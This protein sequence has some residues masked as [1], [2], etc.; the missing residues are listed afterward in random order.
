MHPVST[1]R[2]TLLFG[3]NKVPPQKKKTFTPGGMAGCLASWYFSTNLKNISQNGNLPQIG[4][5][6]KNVWVRVYIYI[7]I[8]YIKTSPQ[9]LNVFLFTLPPKAIPMVK[10]SAWIQAL[11]WGH[12]DSDTTSRSTRNDTDLGDDIVVVPGN[13]ETNGHELWGAQEGWFKKKMVLKGC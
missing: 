5:K 11:L 10:T 13:I 8:L 4:M 9:H 1:S 3:G 2:G 7:Y 6:I 12:E